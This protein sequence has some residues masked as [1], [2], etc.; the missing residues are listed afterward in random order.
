[1]PRDPKLPIWEHP[2][3]DVLDRRLQVWVDIQYTAYR[4]AY[5][6]AFPD[7][8]IQDRIVS[9]AMNR[10]VANLK[11]FRFVRLTPISRAANSSSAHSEKWGVTQ[12]SHPDQMAL[13]RGRGWS[14]QYADF[15][16]VLL[17]LDIHPG[18]KPM[19][20]MRDGLRLMYPRE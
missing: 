19:N 20:A 2:A 1:M 7:E 4:A 16:E 6:R 15:V 13:N 11:G 8:E 18:G 9:H 5:R 17:M 12:H 14:V 10:R 3:C